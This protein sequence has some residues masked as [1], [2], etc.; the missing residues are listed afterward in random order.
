MPDDEPDW[1]W[2]AAASAAGLQEEAGVFLP[3]KLLLMPL[4]IS[5]AF[6]IIHYR[7]W[8][9]NLKPPKGL[10]QIVFD[11]PQDICLHFFVGVLHDGIDSLRL[12]HAIVAM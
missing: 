9:F 2:V 11:K 7:R 12:Y 10:S 3:S 8:R 1:D 6:A 4:A 5:I